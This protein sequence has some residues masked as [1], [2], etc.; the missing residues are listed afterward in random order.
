MKRVGLLLQK[1]LVLID[2]RV[3]KG[4]EVATTMRQYK[5]ELI[6]VARKMR[7]RHVIF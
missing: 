6:A 7:L 5:K 1:E 2:S 3:G 4:D